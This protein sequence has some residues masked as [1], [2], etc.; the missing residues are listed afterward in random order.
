MVI[1][2][3]TSDM[4]DLLGALIVLIIGIYIISAIINA[5]N[6][7]LLVIVGLVVAAIGIL[8]I[9]KEMR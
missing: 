9:L 8:F 2:R 3:R 5:I 6:S 4:I 7:G 1:M